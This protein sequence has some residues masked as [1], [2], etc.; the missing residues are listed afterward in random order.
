MQFVEILH[1]GKPKKVGTWV[2]EK[3]KEELAKDG[4]ELVD[5]SLAKSPS[6]H[7]SEVKKKLNAVVGKA[8]ATVESEDE[9]FEIQHELINPL[10]D[11][12]PTF[13]SEVQDEV[14]LNKAKED[15]VKINE[16]FDLVVGEEIEI[17]VADKTVLEPKKKA[18]RP[19]KA[20]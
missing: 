18:G 1:K 15:D 16:P 3:T 9:T 2:L 11:D 17:P 5:P 6:D 4:I 13:E 14:V 20:K 10:D 12:A 8:E 19:A 7:Q